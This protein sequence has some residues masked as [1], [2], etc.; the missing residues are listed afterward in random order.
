MI[1]PSALA[2]RLSPRAAAAALG[3]SLDLF[4]KILSGCKD[5]MEIL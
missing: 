5:G 1:Y 4:S 3:L 2:S